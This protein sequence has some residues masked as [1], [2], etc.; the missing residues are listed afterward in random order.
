MNEKKK[1][2]IFAGV[3]VVLILLALITTPR[4]RK[5]AAFM[6]Q[7]E[8]FFPNFTDPNEAT[9]MEVVSYDEQTGETQPFKVIFKNG[10]WT[11]PSHHDYPADAKD[12]LAKTAAG[13][14][15]IRKDDYRTDNPADFEACGVLDPVDETTNLTGRGKRVTLKGE[16]DK[17]LADFIIGKTVEGRDG[18]R[19]VRV[20]DQK[21][22]YAVR[23]NVD[24]S[25][26]FNDWIEKDLLKVNRDDIN[27]VVLKDYSIDE[28]MG[29]VNQRDM[30]ILDKKD[31][32]WGANKMPASQ[33]V[34]NTKMTDLLRTIDELSIVGVRPK[35][36]GLSKSLSRAEGAVMI[37][38][39]DVLSLQSKGFYFTRDGQL[40][41]N[42]GEAQ[43]RTKDGLTYTLRFGEIVY[44]TGFDVSAGSDTVSALKAGTGE[45]RYL[46]ITTDFNPKGFSE[47]PKARNTD[48][49][50]KA[51]S[52]LTDADR[53][54]KEIYDKH[55]K[56]QQDIEK[57]QQLSNDL[58]A[59]FANWYYVISAD[60]FEKIN[61]KRKDIVKPKSK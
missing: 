38:Q 32:T 18:F 54:N 12:R 14:I 47:P 59:R 4:T 29:T 42:E 19:F 28:R 37:S 50:G 57:G 48:F 30:L 46:F 40:L 11:I 33:E 22:V 35:P 13:V 10:R 21:R 61:L 15:D 51:D 6:D 58:N 26:K 16:N 31:Q 44:G 39:S 20:P 24:I 43:V 56:W 7:G 23:M 45:N 1:T 5:P 55:E 34:D 8:M 2:L 17:I 49:L 25:T 27:Q 52:L 36:A 3:A 60:S 41:S 53:K 9:A